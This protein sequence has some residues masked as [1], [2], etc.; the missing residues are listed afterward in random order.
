LSIRETCAGAL[1]IES[2]NPNARRRRKR[3]ENPTKG[4]E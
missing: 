2:Q 3:K 4:R 1:S